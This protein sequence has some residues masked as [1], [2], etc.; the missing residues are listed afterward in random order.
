MKTYTV[1]GIFLAFALL[2]LGEYFGRTTLG[3]MTPMAQMAGTCFVI[4]SLFAFLFWRQSG[5]VPPLLFFL[6]GIVLLVLSPAR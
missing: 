5:P 6:A 4:G 3:G 1:F 2:E